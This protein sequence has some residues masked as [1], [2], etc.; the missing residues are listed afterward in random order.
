[1]WEYRAFEAYSLQE[2]AS[3]LN[4]N[5]EGWEL[6]H[7]TEEKPEDL[8]GGPVFTILVRRGEPV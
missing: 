5:H 3:R 6:V 1:M 7:I 8:I 2:V 4:Y